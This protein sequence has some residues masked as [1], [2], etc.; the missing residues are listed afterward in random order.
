MVDD[1]IVGWQS[2]NHFFQL[3]ARISY[4]LH[5]SLLFIGHINSHEPFSLYKEL[6]HVNFYCHVIDFIFIF[7]P[8]IGS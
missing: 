2:Q 7:I 8:P 5:L 3:L 1:I 4:A 6:Y